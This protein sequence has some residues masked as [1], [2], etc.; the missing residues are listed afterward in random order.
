MTKK[1]FKNLFK[2]FSFLLIIDYP[3]LPILLSGIA[4]KSFCEELDWISCG[5]ITFSVTALVLLFWC[6]FWLVNYCVFYM[7]DYRGKKLKRDFKLP[8]YL[9]INYIQYSFKDSKMKP[10][11]IASL[12]IILCLSV[13]CLF[14]YELRNGFIYLQEK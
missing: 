1:Q 14:F 3:L 12:L 13:I 5:I 7:D 2:I 8:F 6:L 4:K 9:Y 10:M 11:I